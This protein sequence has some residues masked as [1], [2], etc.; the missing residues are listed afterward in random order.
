MSVE[1]EKGGGASALLVGHSLW[2]TEG[3]FPRCPGLHVIRLSGQCGESRL[4]PGPSHPLDAL[5]EQLLFTYLSSHF[6]DQLLKQFINVF[7]FAS[8]FW[9]R[10]HLNLNSP[11][12]AKML[13]PHRLKG[14]FLS[15]PSWVSCVSPDPWPGPGRWWISLGLCV[16]GL[17]P[18]DS[19]LHLPASLV[20]SGSFGYS[21]TCK[22][23]LCVLGVGEFGVYPIRKI[24]FCFFPFITARN[25]EF[26]K[27]CFLGDFILGKGKMR[28]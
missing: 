11:P 26:L 23:K 6:S 13:C 27:I 10:S 14:I 20:G 21:A 18:H 22:I 5:S 1:K 28:W 4:R 9:H 24:Y 12:T 7:H 3:N 19:Y 16:L 17:S 8:E 15:Q 25:E 2:V